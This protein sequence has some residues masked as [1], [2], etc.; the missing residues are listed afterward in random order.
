MPPLPHCVGERWGTW[1]PVG[2]FPADASDLLGV[3]GHSAFSVFTSSI[4]FFLNLFFG[5][6]DN[7]FDTSWMNTPI[8]H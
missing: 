6:G 2:H 8:L 1:F 4:H 7:L 3:G 5:F